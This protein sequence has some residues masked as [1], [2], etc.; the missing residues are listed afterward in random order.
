MFRPSIT[1]PASIEERSF[2]IIDAELPEA[3]S[4]GK[5]RHAVLRRVIHATADFDYARNIRFHPDFYGAFLAAVR[6]GAPIVCDVEMVRVGVSRVRAEA[7][8]CPLE[9]PIG[10]KDVAEEAAR[11]GCTRAI[12]AVR[13]AARSGRGGV[14]AVGNA[15]TA[16]TEAVRLVA[17]EG[18]RPDLIIGMAAR[19]GPAPR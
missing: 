9:C 14:L 13:K 3:A 15:P 4:L 19:P 2:E 1:A 12:A 10:D 11:L 5:E 8:G 7:F 16:L 18:W 6:R 17:E